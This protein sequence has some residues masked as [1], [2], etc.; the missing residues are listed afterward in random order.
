[1]KF[2]PSVAGKWTRTTFLCWQTEVVDAVYANRRQ[3]S[4]NWDTPAKHTRSNEPVRNNQNFD[5]KSIA[6]NNNKRENR[7]NWTVKLKGSR[8]FSI[9]KKRIC[10]K[11][12]IVRVFSDEKNFHVFVVVVGYLFCLLNKR[13]KKYK[14]INSHFD[15]FFKW[16]TRFSLHLLLVLFNL[17]WDVPHPFSKWTLNGPRFPSDNLQQTKHFYNG[18]AFHMFVL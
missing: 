18:R 12:K 7:Q 6:N 14:K 17:T 13:S 3:A 11:E 9:G 5:R 10:Q 1:M 16:K 15:R 4:E 2:H 8:P